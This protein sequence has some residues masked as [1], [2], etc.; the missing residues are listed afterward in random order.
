MVIRLYK[1]KNTLP[2]ITVQIKTYHTGLLSEA[3][4]EVEGWDSPGGGPGDA[5]NIVF[6]VG[7][8]VFF[9]QAA[10]WELWFFTPSAAVLTVSIK[11]PKHI[12]NEVT[13]AKLSKSDLKS[14]TCRMRIRGKMTL[15]IYPF[16]ISWPLNRPDQHHAH[17]PNLLNKTHKE[18]QYGYS[19]EMMIQFYDIKSYHWQ[20]WISVLTQWQSCPYHSI[21][22]FLLIANR[23]S[24]VWAAAGTSL[25]R[26]AIVSNH[27]QILL[28][29]AQKFRNNTACLKL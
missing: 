19:T 11:S 9:I 17:L 26:V 18:S 2:I 12:F 4:A 13:T 8:T 27:L 7:L 6:K 29:M 16:G 3:A 10:T 28:N 1:S 24:S 21:G 14:C 22:R 5:G 20:L 25:P 15:N 23:L